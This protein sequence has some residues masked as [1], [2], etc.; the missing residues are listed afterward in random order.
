MSL[1]LEV[2]TPTPVNPLPRS[3]LMGSE[4][5][6][7]LPLSLASPR[8]PLNPSSND[9]PASPSD[10]EVTRNAIAT[11][12]ATPPL[13]MV[14]TAAPLVLVP[15]RMSEAAPDRHPRPDQKAATASRGRL[16]EGEERSYEEA[17]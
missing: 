7:L 3:S 5:S 10:H 4:L 17:A 12:T 13:E 11:T 9:G 14:R 15:A 16:V 1:T 8:P 2:A 6:R